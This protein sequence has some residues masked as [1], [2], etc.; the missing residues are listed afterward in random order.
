[1]KAS[2]GPVLRFDN[3]SRAFQTQLGVY[4]INKII[5]LE[6]HEVKGCTQPPS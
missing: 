6:T 1:M 5:F 3:I 4:P 2:G